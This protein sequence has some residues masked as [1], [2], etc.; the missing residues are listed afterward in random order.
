MT[1]IDKWAEAVGPET[2]MNYAIPLLSQ[3]NPELRTETLN[4]V[5][6]NKESIPEADH[7]TFVKPLML[8]LQDKSPTI[9]NNTELV[10]VVVM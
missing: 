2:V 6:K 1:C 9:R 4:W 10:I 5:L 7:S 3:E 8:L